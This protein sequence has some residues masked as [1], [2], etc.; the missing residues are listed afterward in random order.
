MKYNYLLSLIVVC[1]FSI[2]LIAQ[3]ENAEIN[4][5]FELAVKLFN[6]GKFEEAQSIFKKIITGYHYNSKTTASHFFIAKIYLE[7]EEFA[8]ARESLLR[9]YE[10]YPESR[11]ADEIGMMLIKT[12]VEEED[13]YNAFR[14]AV[15]V[16]EKTKSSSYKRKAKNAAEKIAYNYLNST[17]LQRL[18]G[19]YSV[20]GA[21]PFI[22]LQLG[23]V[24]LKEGDQF[25][26][27]STLAEIIKD[28]TESDEYTKAKMLYDSP[29]LPATGSD[30]LTLIGV[31]LPLE[32]N[33]AGEYT[34]ETA[35]EI[36]EGIKLAV[37][38]F[39]HL[40]ENKIG[41]IIRDT[42]KDA[43]EI[44]KIRDEFDR[45]SSVKVILGPIYSNEVRAAL[46]EFEDT[47]IPMISPT[48]TDDDLVGLNENFFQ[49]NPSFTKRGR[50]I[51]QYIF[52]VEN[53]KN[54]SILNAIEGY[55]PLLASNFA[56]EFE[57]LGGTILKRES[58]KSK[59][60]SLA[61]QISRI[62][63]DSLILDGLYIPLA[64]NI[65]APVILSH[66]V[67]F[68]LKPA[69]Y[70]NQDWFTAK[71]FETSPEISNQLT[72][73]SDY[74]IEF[75]STD[76]Q[77]F[78]NLYS[79]RTGKDVNRNVLYGFDTAKYLLTVM[80]NIDNTRTNIRN[81]M[82]SG[83]TSM[84]FHNNISFD[85]ERVNRFLNIVRYKNGVFELLDKFRAGNN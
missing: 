48:A 18:S 42:K 44:K 36:L 52:Y 13:W 41:L 55:S 46:H 29:F 78:N 28:Y 40:R 37:S 73:S 9:F 8:E 72:F 79:G 6:S 23:K 3:S 80:R 64:D 34:S 54:I 84:G 85:E 39:N 1:L 58:Y 30:K 17:Q 71:G 26:A 15:A 81:K 16:I 60:Y 47:N 45:S 14:N 7:R 65:D 12:S 82:I 24:Y 63:A 83:V 69:V 10:L 25:S 11:Y 53:K 27:K 22:L 19:I 62:A 32:T 56:E 66:L 68:N 31:M 61:E 43:D 38:E 74:F 76:Y 77:A 50:I 51:A 2:S 59:T 20:S 57:K 49:A 35:S 33:S 4:S 5:Q 75:N 21:K 70:G 67:Q